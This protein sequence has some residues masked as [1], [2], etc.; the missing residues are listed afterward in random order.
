[1]TESGLALKGVTKRFGDRAAVDAIAFTVPEGALFGLLGPNGAG[2]TTTIRMILSILE[3]DAGAIR[4]GERP[5]RELPRAALGYLPEERG[6]YPRM[7]VREQLEFFARLRELDADRARARTQ[8]WLERMELSE[9]AD[10]P[11]QELSKGNQQKVQLACAVVH[12]PRLLVLDEPF[13]GLDPINHR[14]FEAVVRELNA[15]G[16]T[17]L[18]S[19]HDMEQVEALCREV[20]LLHEGRLLFAG[21]LA[22]LRRRHAD[23]ERLRLR[24]AGDRGA[25]ERRFPQL[26]VVARG[27]GW[28]ELAVEGDADAGDLLGTAIR[29]GQVDRFRREQPSLREIFIAEVG[30]KR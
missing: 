24:Y 9:H 8:E 12:G 20:A 19:T 16:T 11:T 14:L 2:K 30:A 22:E 10:Q 3:P 6:L 7:P 25:L 23:R 26:E 29:H 28:W 4:W 15:D 1:M 17:I 27:D 18:L 5:V 13:S 21:A